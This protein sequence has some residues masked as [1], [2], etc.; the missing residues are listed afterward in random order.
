MRDW[1]IRAGA[2]AYARV[3]ERTTRAGGA[4][5]SVLAERA[6]QR[7]MM[8]RSSAVGRG[9]L[10][11]GSFHAAARPAV[12]R[13]AVD[14]ECDSPEAA[15]ISQIWSMSWPAV[16]PRRQP[17]GSDSAPSSE[18]LVIDRAHL[19][20]ARPAR[21][22]GSDHRLTDLAAA[23]ADSVMLPASSSSMMTG[24]P[25]LQHLAQQEVCDDRAC[26][27]LLVRASRSVP[28][29]TMLS[30]LRGWRVRARTACEVPLDV[31]T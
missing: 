28:R 22:C 9:A 23:V 30:E 27:R 6:F 18:Q 24:D 4:G 13:G 20:E 2:A 12:G 14:A 25:C 11:V 21:A 31:E 8:T 15:T 19:P 1:R 17:S 3:G 29:R 16:D 7:R 10:A 5:A 26:I